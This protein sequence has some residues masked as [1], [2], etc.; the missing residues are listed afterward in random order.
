MALMQI[1]KWP[2]PILQQTAAPVTDFDAALAALAQDMLDTMYDAPGRGL[3]APQVGRLI[4]LFVMDTTW[5]EGTPDPV[6]C[7]NPEILWSSDETEEN[8]EG[9]LSIPGTPMPIV[10][11]ARIGLRWQGVDGTVNEAEL[12]GPDALC[13]QHE[14]DHLDGL[15]IFDRVAPSL[16]AE[17]EARYSAAPT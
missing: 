10:R 12:D 8:E 16:R 2:D 14:I 17:L 1:L 13:A 6:V 15:V 7:V 5:K 3:A 4:R 9:C 11:P